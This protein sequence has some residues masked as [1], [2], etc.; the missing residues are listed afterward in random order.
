MAARNGIL[1][2]WTPQ[3]EE[4][5]DVAHP[6]FALLCSS[7]KFCTPLP[8]PSACECA[9]SGSAT[10]SYPAL[11]RTIFTSTMTSSFFVTLSCL[12]GWIF[13]FTR[14]MNSRVMFVL[15]TGSRALSQ[16]EPQSFFLSSSSRPLSFLSTVPLF[17]FFLA[18][19]LI[20]KTHTQTI[21]PEINLHLDFSKIIIF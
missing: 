21:N 14:S 17:F 5:F 8:F 20:T 9:L 18:F 7:A 4:M 3:R 1:S 2:V 13:E 12:K 16:R 19:V 10:R 11:S 6:T 15:S